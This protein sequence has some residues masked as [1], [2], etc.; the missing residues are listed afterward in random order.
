ML[1]LQ[2]GH[3]Y[4]NDATPSNSTPSCESVGAV[5]IQTTT[6]RGSVNNPLALGVGAAHF[7]PVARANFLGEGSLNSTFRREIAYPTTEGENMNEH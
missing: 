3:A 4:L 7:I 5:F 2:Q 6:P 1:F